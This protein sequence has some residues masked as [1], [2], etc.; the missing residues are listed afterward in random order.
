MLLAYS[1]IEHSVGK[2]FL[3]YIQAIP[4]RHRRRNNYQFRFLSGKLKYG[5]REYFTI[6]GAIL[7]EVYI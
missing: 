1:D 5:L 4:F 6:G 2:F 3:D 7:P